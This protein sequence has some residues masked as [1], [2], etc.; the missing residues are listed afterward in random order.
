MF[1]GRLAH[2]SKYRTQTKGHKIAKFSVII[3][4]DTDDS[5]EEMRAAYTVL[6]SMTAVMKMSPLTSRVYMTSAPVPALTFTVRHDKGAKAFDNL[7]DALLFHLNT[8]ETMHPRTRRNNEPFFS[9]TQINVFVSN[10]EADLDIMWSSIS[11]RFI[12]GN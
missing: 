12:A 6:A 7:R 8:P 3:D 10:M 5:T 11:N 2:T 9:T 1:P 4:I